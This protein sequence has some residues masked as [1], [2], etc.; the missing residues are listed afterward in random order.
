M[1]RRDLGLSRLWLCQLAVHPLLRMLEPLTPVATAWS[2]RG[3][4]Q[5]L[6]VMPCAPPRWPIRSPPVAAL[7]ASGVPIG[8]ADSG[9]SVAQVA[10]PHGHAFAARCRG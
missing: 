2:P 5:V 4:D 7:P 3:R 10:T 1:Q 9:T 8:A 6:A